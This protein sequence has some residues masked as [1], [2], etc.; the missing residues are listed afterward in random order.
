MAIQEFDLEILYWSGKK[1]ANVDS[2]SCY[3]TSSQ[4]DNEHHGSFGILAM[5]TLVDESEGSR[6]I[7]EQQ[8]ADLDL[9]A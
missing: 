1:N 8:L 3:P 2:L 4:K 5:L 6:L 7:S 9:I